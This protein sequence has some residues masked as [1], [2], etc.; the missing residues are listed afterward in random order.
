VTRKLLSAALVLIAGCGPTRAEE[1]EA[2]LPPGLRV[3]RAGG[4]TRVDAV[5]AGRL[6]DFALPSSDGATRDVVA[7][8]APFPEAAAARGEGA[9]GPRKLPP[10][11]EAAEPA[12]RLY[13]FAADG[14][15]DLSLL[16]DDLPATCDALHAT[17]VDGDGLDDL[18]VSCD[19]VLL[20]FALP[21][22]R[23]DDTDGGPRHLVAAPH[24]VWRFLRPPASP[25]AGRDTPGVVAGVGLGS[26]TLYGRGADGAWGPVSRI[27]L[28]VEG[29]YR[30]GALRITSEIPAFLGVGADG[31]LTFVTEPVAVGAR[32]LRT[33]LIEFTS[34]AGA[35]VTE[36]WSS[37]PQNEDVLESVPLM[38]DG[39]PAMFVTTKPAGKLS[40]FG[41]KRIRIHA[42][43][44][45]RS[46]LGTTPLFS[47]DSRMNLWQESVPALV[48][49]NGDGLDDLVVGFWK[50]LMD[51]KVVLDAYLREPSGAFRVAPR[52]TDLD[53]EGGDRG[54]LLYGADLD[55]DRLADLLVR[56]ERDL[57]IYPGLPS[58][59]GKRLVADEPRVIPTG[60]LGPAGGP[61]QVRVSVG[62]ATGVDI[63]PVPGR[64][65][66]ADL[67]SDGVSEILILRRGGL[68]EPGALRILWLHEAR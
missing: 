20:A 56:T 40:L 17:D 68:D 53:V 64:P 30:G 18:V 38:L 51:E 43:A 1:R 28:P 13:R 60:G 27:E 6:I 37:L 48:D 16:R 14:S 54:V 63:G 10:C 15:G 41:E 44:R 32:R 2:V 58:T 31:A 46:R 36:C 45:D 5:F 29:A 24:T 9:P 35:H 22:P 42:L 12:L 33:L 19:G 61:V 62:Q 7:L 47:A 39:K 66:L 34:T 11:S 67:D 8:V 4:A 26:F 55:G 3:E 50:G 57:R 49:V 23:G 65:K 25:L 21:Q 59:D 52:T